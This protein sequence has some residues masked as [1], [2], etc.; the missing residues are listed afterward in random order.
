MAENNND[1]LI[2]Q[3]KYF[4]TIIL[5]GIGVL[6]LV[7]LTLILIRSQAKDASD[8]QSATET[9]EASTDGK[10]NQGV[11]D[12]GSEADK[13]IILPP[14]DVFQPE[15]VPNI[16]VVSWDFSSSTVTLQIT[17]SSSQTIDSVGYGWPSLY[18]PGGCNKN[19]VYYAYS[20]TEFLGITNRDAANSQASASNSQRPEP[21]TV[22]EY[23]ITV[24][25]EGI[26][27]ICFIVNY[28]DGNDQP[29]QSL[30]KDYE[31]EE[32][33]PSRG[34]P[35]S[36]EEIAETKK[37]FGDLIDGLDL[38]PLGEELVYGKY[39][40]RIKYVPDDFDNPDLFWS[41]GY[42]D[43]TEHTFYSKI[44][45]IDKAFL[46]HEFLHHIWDAY[47]PI[48]EKRALAIRIDEVILE[49]ENPDYFKPDEVDALKDGL[50]FH[51]G[52]YLDIKNEDFEYGFEYYEFSLNQALI[53]K[54]PWRSDE[55]HSIFAEL[56]RDLPEDLE[57]YYAKYFNNRAIIPQDYWEKQEALL[58]E[59][60]NLPEDPTAILEE[61]SEKPSD[62]P[63]SDEDAP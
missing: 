3:A 43:Q 1:P 21:I 36:P 45:D 34:A 56:I 38:T 9:P 6:L 52:Y 63:E 59:L 47:L 32:S 39:G 25:G 20:L 48:E 27:E 7:S 35:L 44:K 18:V 4:K 49:L 17:T 60:S 40:F 33:T 57:K 14:S 5:A 29:G 31:P 46:T 22:N 16:E 51:A 55:L 28:R 54:Q 58:E 8:N 24:P 15:I 26:A 19:S 12:S 50:V 62:E 23:S 30:I 11:S 37:H 2:S 42:Y 61:D 53:D 13:T 10:P 41:E